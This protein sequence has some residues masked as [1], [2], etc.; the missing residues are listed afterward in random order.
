MARVAT[1][2]QILLC[3]ALAWLLFGG[4][5]SADDF[6]SYFKESKAAMTSGDWDRAIGL[7]TKAIKDNPKF[8]EGYHNRGIAYSK[9][10]EYDKSIKDLLIAVKLKPNYPES[11]GLL[12]LVYEIKK[13]YKRARQA[14]Q[15]ALDTE[16]R[17]KIK[18]LVRTW[19]SSLDAKIGKK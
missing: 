5:A 4:T 17:P 10:G 16:K 11:Y 6:E 18:E 19:I 7:L 13:D 15:I 12:G 8:Y 2:F 14:Y 3:A 1:P 9:K